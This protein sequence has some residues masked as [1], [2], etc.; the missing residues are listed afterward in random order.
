MNISLF[1]AF[2][3]L[4]PLRTGSIR[5]VRGAILSIGLSLVPLIVVLQV[6]DGM[7][8]GITARILEVGTYHLQVLN[9]SNTSSPAEVFLISELRTVRT[10]LSVTEETQ[11]VALAYTKGG[12]A[13]VTI[14][15]VPPRLWELDKGFA[16]FMRLVEGTFDLSDP[17]SAVLGAELASKLKVHL[18]DTVKVVTPYSME[19]DSVLSRVSTFTVKGVVSSGYQ[20]LDKLWLFISQERSRILS[21]RASRKLIGIKVENPFRGL[22]PVV[23]EVYRIL[24]RS[25]RVYTWEELE[26]SRYL[27]FRTTQYLLIFIMALI[28][29][30]AS[31]NISSTLI[32]LQIEKRDE[33]AILRSMGLSSNQTIRLFYYI[34]TWL[35]V[36]GTLVGVSIGLAMAVY[37]NEIIGGIEFLLNN[38]WEVIRSILGG[39]GMVEEGRKILIL[40]PQFYLERIPI[41]ID[42]AKVFGAAFFAVL[43]SVLASILPARTAGRLKPLEVL[44]KH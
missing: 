8:Q 3:Y 15:A 44:V 27:S 20:E 37:I 41:V 12:N 4:S 21:P 31:V 36:L 32:L 40:N 17:R 11:G 10:V 9:P 16:R 1:L 24:P 13:G 35:G 14:R 42:P 33:L 23:Q 25:Y 43:L 38:G 18:G 34:G 5:R 29:A 30:V 7:I 6:S 28:L 39:T 19:G 26:S 2:R 22:L